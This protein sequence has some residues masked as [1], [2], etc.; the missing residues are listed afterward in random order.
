M[1]PERGR[2]GDESPVTRCRHHCPF[3]DPTGPPTRG[4]PGP[5]T[6]T[7]TD[8]Y[9]LPGRQVELGR[10]VRRTRTLPVQWDRDLWVVEGSSFSGRVP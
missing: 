6:T 5:S 2:G 9:P 8:T 7:W 1:T 3:G 4:T 10:D